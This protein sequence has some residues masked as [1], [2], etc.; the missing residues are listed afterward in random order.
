MVATVPVNVGDT[1]GT[2]T[3]VVTL[4][5]NEKIATLSLNEVDAAKV[6]VGDKVTLTFDA[7]DGLSLTGI[8]VAKST[9]PAP[10]PKASFPIQSKS[11]LTPKMT[12]SKRE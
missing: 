7:I 8:V 1:I 11:A 4:I 9:P 2:G 5:T 10:F 6:K 12:E 3:T